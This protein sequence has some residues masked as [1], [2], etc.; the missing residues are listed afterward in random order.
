MG[1][2]GIHPSHYQSTN[3]VKMHVHYKVEYTQQVK[4]EMC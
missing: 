1:S 2:T 4:Q 3:N